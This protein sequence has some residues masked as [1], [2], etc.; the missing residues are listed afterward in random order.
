MLSILIPVYNFDVRALV[1]DLHSQALN[2]GKA[3]EIVCVDDA[4]QENFRVLNRELSSLEHVRYQELPTN[5]GRSVIRN[6]LAEMALYPFLLF[7]DCDS[8][9]ENQAYISNYLN[10][11]EEGKVIYGGRTYDPVKP[12]D[13]LLYFRWHYGKEREVMPY[14]KRQIHPYRSFMTNNFLIPKNIFLQVKM[15]E[16]I[17]GYGHEDTLF[18]QELAEKGIRIEHIDNPLRHIGLE[19][20]HVFLEQSKNGVKNLYT[21]ILR[22]KVNS[23]NRLFSAYRIIKRMFLKKIFLKWFRKKKSS[24]E[25]DLLG[26]Q[27]SLRI[28]DLYK[29]GLLLET[30]EEEMKKNNDH[31]TL[32]TTTA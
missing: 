2:C 4:S 30:E 26:P 12:S 11:A 21:L 16:G 18:A 13:P 10:V 8:Q 1:R 15:D 27:P 17:K 31:S 7:M 29:L 32:N 24:M 6:L 5:T 20:N 9:T 14:H 23:D 28:F 22:R 25:Q 3:F 19:I